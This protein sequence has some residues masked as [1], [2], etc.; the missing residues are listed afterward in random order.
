MVIL[1]AKKVVSLTVVMLSFV[2]LV[3]GLVG[4]LL[5]QQ[6]AAQKRIASIDDFGARC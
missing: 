4:D 3:H 1:N 6:P 5:A 2:L